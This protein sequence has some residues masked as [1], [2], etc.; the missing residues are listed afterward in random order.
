MNQIRIIP[1]LDILNGRV[2]KGVNFVNI[3]DAGDPLEIAAA[4]SQSGADELAFLDISATQQG[5]GIL[6]DLV[7]QTAKK[8]TIP[9]TVGGGIRNLKDMEAV[10]DAGADKVSINSAALL[11]PELISE[12]A[13]RFGSQSL[14][15]AID[16]KRRPDGGYDVYTRGGN[17]NAN[18]DA[19]DWAREV[20]QLGAGEILLT[21]MD[22]DGT[23]DGYDIQLTKTVVQAVQI[24]VT[25]SGGAGRLEHFAQAVIEG[26]AS[27]L[28]AASLFHYG[29][30]T[31]MDVKRYLQDQ[32][33]P[34][35]MET[36]P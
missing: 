28:L 15:V 29:E 19:V 23:K 6:L 10:L 34:V 25:A 7:K 33:I 3:K 1:C 26:G 36:S 16:A 13:K 11:N 12:A 21:S 18:R 35:R 2:V 20:E 27:A 32:G 5:R 4:Y 17:T 31:I 8:V 24:P 22:T 30:L 14:V 9:F